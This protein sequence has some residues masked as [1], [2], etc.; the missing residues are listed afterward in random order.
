MRVSIELEGSPAEVAP[1]LVRLGAAADSTTTG[2]RAQSRDDWTSAQA[3]ELVERITPGA[4][5]ALRLFMENA[6][7][8]SFD[9]LQGHL[10]MS[11]VQVGGVMAS[12]GFAENA[13]MA[14]PYR[15]DR[16]RR[17]YLIDPEIAPVL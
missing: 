11:G 15:V 7:E 8:V 3:D 17:R 12:F 4:R 14:R 1:Y 10:G 9:D 2:S 16:D 5:R 13:G 6:P